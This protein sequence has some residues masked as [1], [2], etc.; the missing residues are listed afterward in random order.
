MLLSDL[1]H[2]QAYAEK[3]YRLGNDEYTTSVAA[4]VQSLRGEHERAAALYREAVEKNP[5]Y[6]PARFNLAVEYLEGKKYRE[7]LDILTE[8]DRTFGDVKDLM[9][10][11]ILNNMGY[12]L[13][14]LGDRDQAADR[15]RQALAVTPDFPDAKKNL[16]LI[17]LGRSP[18]T[19][20]KQSSQTAPSQQFLN[21]P[22]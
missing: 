12:A 7:G 2:A 22:E 13:W 14:W 10:S 3:G 21:Q 9:R 11:K 6:I 17:S 18:E 1:D 15:F 16:E 4:Y 5:G 20:A 8:L 19:A